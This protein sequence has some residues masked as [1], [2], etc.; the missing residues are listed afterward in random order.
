MKKTSLALAGLAL[1][2]AGPAFAD[3][4]D[5]ATV[6]VN[7]T[8][9]AALTVSNGTLTMPHIV[10]PKAALTAGGG[11]PTGGTST[12]LVTCDSA[13]VATITYGAGANPYADGTAGNTAVQVGSA[14]IANG[15]STATCANLTVTGQSGYFFLT[16]VGSGTIS[17]PAAGVTMPATSCSSTSSTVLTGGS[18][19]IYCGA[20]INV[21]T[22]FVAASGTYTGTF[23]VTVTY[24]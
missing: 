10:K 24:D 19:S 1:F 12:V 3:N 4:T 2:C 17:S 22:A 7:G 14:N 11:G 21:T 23:P 15:G 9:V 13:G 8:I 5:T 18:V 16:N 20:Q 6:T